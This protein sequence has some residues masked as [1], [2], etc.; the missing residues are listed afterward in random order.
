LNS[1]SASDAA[2]RPSGA[3]G[4]VLKNSRLPQKSRPYSIR[5]RI[6]LAP[7]DE[8]WISF[9][10]DIPISL[11]SIAPIS[12]ALGDALRSLL[13]GTAGLGRGSPSRIRNGLP[14]LTA[15]DEFGRR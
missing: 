13:A 3:P 1:R 11:P 10:R 5:R 14:K 7:D 15:K 2:K 6:E 8:W 4:L 9:S 12:M